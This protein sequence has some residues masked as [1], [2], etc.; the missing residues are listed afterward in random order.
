MES[1]IV[2]SNSSVIAPTPSA[3]LG[4]PEIEKAKVQELI[5]KLQSGSLEAVHS[6]GRDL[7]VRYILEG[8]MQPSGE[9]VRVNAEL[10]AAD[11]GA[12][13][14]AEQFD[15][16]RTD[17]LQAQDTIVAHLAHTM[18]FELTVAEGARVQRGAANPSAEDLALRCDAGAWK[19][20]WIGKEA[21]A[22]YALCEQALALDPNNVRALRALGG[23]YDMLVVVGVS[24]DRKG[25]LERGDQLELK[26][27]AV[28]PDCAWA[29]H[30]RGDILRF[31]G[32]VEE[33]FAEHQ[34]ALALDP[35]LAY[36]AGSLG[37]DYQFLGQFDKSLEY[38][39]RALRASPND[40]A[41]IYWHVGRAL[42]EFALKRY[43][44]AIELARQAI[45]INPNG[46]PLP[47]AVLV[48]AL[49]LS[50]REREARE[51]L[52]RY[53]ALL[54]SGGGRT[55]AAWKAVHMSFGGDPR[56]VEANER[57]RDGLRKS[58]MPEQ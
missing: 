40:P 52:Q 58:G 54:G 9:R 47:H 13:L 24:G 15:T 7:G 38:L 20:G 2:L 31:Q 43:D 22:A 56:F 27:L 16:P 14:W 3:S 29:H 35:S 32:R 36:A 50:G 55:I 21:E 39:D 30:I 18:N 46:F 23:K 45:A 10:I 44:R 33:A 1:E 25:D 28:D 53:F 37:V 5:V 11:S 48:A 26:A 6:F 19:A 57:M 34:R 4:L 8:S 17:L 51:A 12:H 42:S 41:L 49:A